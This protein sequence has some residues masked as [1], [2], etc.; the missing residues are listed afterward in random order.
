MST[1]VNPKQKALTGRQK[2]FAENYTNPDSDTFLNGTQSALQAGYAQ[3]PK[4]AAVTAHNNIRKENV[5]SYMEQLNRD[6]GYGI[7]DRS[8]IRG[9]IAKG[10]YSPKTISTHY[11]EDGNPRGKT[12]VEKQ[13]TIDQ[14]IKLDDLTNRVEGVYNKANVAEHVAKRE[15]DER[16]NEL[17]EA[18]MKALQARQ[19][20]AKGAS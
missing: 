18:R 7:E 17:R 6:N 11:D 19:R 12:V 4:Q 3:N 10:L 2:R 9:N 15:H 8:S 16:I 14:L 20:K 13:V 5:L 1:E